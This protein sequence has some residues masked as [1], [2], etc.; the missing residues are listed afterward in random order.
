MGRID[1]RNKGGRAERA[2]KAKLNEWWGCEFFRTP[3]SGSLS[4]LGWELPGLSIEGDLTTVDES[5]PFSVECKHVEGWRLEQYMTA[6]KC[7]LWSFWNQTLRSTSAER[8]PLLFFRKNRHPWMFAMRECDLLLD[9]SGTCVTVK[10][11]DHEP[12]VVGLAEDLWSTSKEDWLAAW[13]N[14][15]KKVKPN[16]ACQETDG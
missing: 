15:T 1:S 14:D 13:Q 16:D 2:L 7:D 5:F 12:F 3:G 11:A 6:P 8:Q 10:S 4:T 9:L